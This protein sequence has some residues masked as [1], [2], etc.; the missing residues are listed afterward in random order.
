MGLICEL[1]YRNLAL[2]GD[3]EELPD[4]T[5]PI[6]PPGETPSSTATSTTS[7]LS[8]TPG[9]TTTTVIGSLGKMPTSS[10]P[11]YNP[12]SPTPTDSPDAPAPTDIPEV[13]TPT[14][15]S[16]NPAST[17]NV[18]KSSVTSGLENTAVN[19][20]TSD[21]PRPPDNT[22][23]NNGKSLRANADCELQNRDS[24]LLLGLTPIAQ[25]ASLVLQ[26]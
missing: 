8:V 5:T 24:A 13:P 23:T 6:E 15:N 14:D 2:L 1:P 21:L 22:N 7:T 18:E 9:I 3:P 25:L 20:H 10:T 26:L 19:T 16:G 12:G 4:P 17:R 11:T